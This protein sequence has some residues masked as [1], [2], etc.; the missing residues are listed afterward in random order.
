MRTAPP[1]DWLT[2]RPVREGVRH[3]AQNHERMIAQIRGQ[4]VAR[5]ADQVVVDCG[6]VGYQLSVSSRA[7]QGVPGTG[8]QVTLLAHL[9]VRE[10]AMHLYG[11]ASEAERELF[12]SLISV[13]GVGPK[14]AISA[15]SGSSTSE[16]RHAIASGD[17]KRFQ[18]VPGIG[19]KTAERIIVE[20]REKVADDLTSEI[21]AGAEVDTDDARLLAREGLV[22]LGYE[23][24]EAER[25]LDA[26]GA[27]IEISEPEELIAA[28]LRGAAKAA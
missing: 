25:L 12:L 23:L 11:F 4:V 7:L 5:A 18:A 22:T 14:M 19:K 16:I 1:R 8:K 10:D 17:A 6:G 24:V 21:S 27:D 15:L 20:L 9:I 2:K 13:G 28:A 26:V 3:A